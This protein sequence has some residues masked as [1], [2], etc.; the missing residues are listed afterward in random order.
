MTNISFEELG[1]E[2]AEHLVDNWA[3]GVVLDDAEHQSAQDHVFEEHVQHHGAFGQEQGKKLFHGE[4]QLIV[5][6]YEH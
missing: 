6:E 4:E 2:V 3:G 5:L 1:V